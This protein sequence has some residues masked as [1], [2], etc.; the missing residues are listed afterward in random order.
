MHACSSESILVWLN[1]TVHTTCVSTFSTKV[2]L[3]TT[4]YRN[5]TQ[6]R[7]SRVMELNSAYNMLDNNS[8]EV[9]QTAMQQN[10][11][12][13]PI[14]STKSTSPNVRDSTQSDIDGGYTL[15]Q[16]KNVG[17]R[18]TAKR[19]RSYNALNLL[20]EEPQNTHT[21]HD[22][23][24][25]TRKEEKPRA[26]TQTTKVNCIA[27]G[28]GSILLLLLLAVISL[29]V[30]TDLKQSERFISTNKQ[31][32]NIN[33]QIQNKSK[34]MEKSNETTSQQLKSA[35][36]QLKSMTEQIRSMN[37]FLSQFPVSSCSEIPQDRP[38]GEYWI[39]TNSTSTPVRVYCDMN[40]TS[41]SCNTAGG[42]TRVANLDMTDSNQNCPD[43]F[44]LVSRS[45]PPL[46][47]C[48]R[49]GP[50]C[51]ST[52]YSTHG[53]EYSRVCGRIKAIYKVH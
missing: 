19:N 32:Q 3:Y 52:T 46:R 26:R 4:G 20:E 6:H 51:T 24:L 27:I 7:V 45:E 12:Y 49:T 48:G 22:L 17:E 31:L 11:A 44:R 30:Y 40:R 33:Q 9:Q 36:E 53:I 34:E 16:N 37:A 18:F 29:I 35:N 38:S 42:W 14:S 28:F 25:D 15:V 23:L 2:S 43:G 50:G 39:V 1:C 13:N 41:C 8:T 10:A 21:A 5:Q 47:T